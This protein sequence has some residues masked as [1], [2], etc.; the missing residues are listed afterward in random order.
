[1]GF[2]LAVGARAPDFTLPATDGRTWSLSDFRDAKVLVVFF[3]CNHCPYVKGSDELT[4]HAADT[5]APKGVRFVGI[6]S[7]SAITHPD[8]DFPA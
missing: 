1:M 5:Y 8:D 4:R 2:T 7:N 6:N 3:T